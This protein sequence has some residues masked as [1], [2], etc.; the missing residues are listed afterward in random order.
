[1][2]I[3]QDTANQTDTSAIDASLWAS[4]ALRVSNVLRDFVEVV[5]RGASWLI[6]PVV[7]ITVM[8]A[9]SRKLSLLQVWLVENVSMVFGS[10]ILQELEWHF[11]TGLFALVL[12]YGFIYN[13]HVRVDVVREHLQFRSKAM[14]EFCGLT[15]FMIP[16]CGIIIWFAVDW[17]HTSWILG[18]ISAS[19]VGIPYR[20][21]IKSVLLAGM[22]VA[23]ISGIAVWLQVVVVLWGPR[24]ARFDLCTLEWPEEETKIEGKER[25]QI[26]YGLSDDVMDEISDDEQPAGAGASSQ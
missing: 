11:H 3:Q 10:T 7:L 13:A 15:F 6:M 2:T 16:F 19:Q 24:E 25:L 23:M 8:D 20:W 4:V 22:V 18:E 17:V 1:M 26:D 12:G 5:G 14:L 9:S 21:A